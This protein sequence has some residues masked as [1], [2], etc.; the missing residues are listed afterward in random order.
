[1]IVE[2]DGPGYVFRRLR[3]EAGVYAPGEVT[4]LAGL[5]SCIFCVSVWA[6]AILYVTRGLR[7]PQWILAVSAGA[8][9]VNRAIDKS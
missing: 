6:A 8:L 1:M 4:F 7:F 5:L 9:L 2:E 3:A